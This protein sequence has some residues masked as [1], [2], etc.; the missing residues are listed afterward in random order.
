MGAYAPAGA[1]WQ[2]A[3]RAERDAP[4]GGGRNR[5]PRAGSM[6]AARWGSILQRPAQS[7]RPRARSKLRWT[8]APSGSCAATAPKPVL[9]GI[10]L[11]V[12]DRDK[13][14]AGSA[15]SRLPRRRR[16][17][18]RLRRAFSLELRLAGGQALHVEVPALPRR[19]ARH[20]ADALEAQL[21]VEARRLEGIGVQVQQQAAA[22][23]RAA[24]GLLRSAGGRFPGGAPFPRAT[25]A[26]RSFPSSTTAGSARP[27]IVLCR[28][29]R[30][31]RRACSE[32]D[33]PSCGCSGS[34][35]SRACARPRARSVRSATMRSL[36]KPLMR[37]CGL[38]RATSG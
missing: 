3:I 29:G 38:A 17:H 37:R 8:P 13:R 32:T 30:S 34:G 19:R 9:A 14:H 27:A 5:M 33:L 7:A 12:A 1:G 15:R 24:L 16:P 23:A 22:P 18:R 26:R 2:K 11:Q 35:R 21:F 28:R 25:A 36:P 10:E 20:A 6:S 31:A 4:H